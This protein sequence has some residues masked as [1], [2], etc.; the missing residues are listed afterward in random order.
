MHQ[1]HLHT[2]G[3]YGPVGVGGTCGTWLHV[4]TVQ[5]DRP[6]VGERSPAGRTILEVWSCWHACAEG[7][8]CFEGRGVPPSS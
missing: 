8:R 2:R 3:S 4:E 7:R 1:W 6:V 5:G